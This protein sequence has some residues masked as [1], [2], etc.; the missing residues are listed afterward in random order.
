M[1]NFDIFEIVMRKLKTKDIVSCAGV[2]KEWRKNAKTCGNMHNA[3]MYIMAAT[4][5]DPLG[6]LSE[7]IETYIVHPERIEEFAEIFLDMSILYNVNCSEFDSLKEMYDENGTSFRYSYLDHK[8][9]SMVHGPDGTKKTNK[10]I[11]KRIK[12]YTDEVQDNIIEVKEEYI[13]GF[14]Q[15]IW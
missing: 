4:C 6:D 15:R 14:S 13:Q 11:R 12:S 3:V 1:E 10:K 2:C 5:R 7:D 8:T 9:L